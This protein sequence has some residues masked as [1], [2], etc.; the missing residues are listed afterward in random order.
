MIN[1]PQKP[2]YTIPK[3][4]CPIALLECAGKL[5]EKIIAK[6]INTDIEQYNLLPMTQFGSRPKHN[7]IDAV[8]NLVHKIQSTVATSHVGALLLFDISGFFDNVN[9]LCTTEIL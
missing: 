6:C 7:A 1:K 4:Y 8:A 9:P 3:A 2:D 5:L